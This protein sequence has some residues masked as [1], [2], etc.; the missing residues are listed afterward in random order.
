MLEDETQAVSAS[1]AT[2]VA[3]DSEARS[4]PQRRSGIQRA[5]VQPG[6]RIGE[7]QRFEI[8]EQAGVGGMG[9][10]FRANDRQL[11]RSVAIKFFVPDHVISPDELGALLKQEARATARLS[12]EN[13]VRIFDLGQWNGLPFLV[14]EY[15]EGEPLTAILKRQRFDLPRATDLMIEVAQG[16]DH[17]HGHGIIHRDLK[18]AN[19]LILKSGR[20]KIL[21]FGIAHFAGPKPL[22]GG[23]APKPQKVVG[24]PAYMAPEQW[25]GGEQDG[26]VDIW[27]AGVLYYELL[28]GKL[29]PWGADIPSIFAWLSSREPAPSARAVRPDLPEAVDAI[30]A[31]ALTRQPADR[32]ENARAFIDA[33]DSVRRPSSL[34]AAPDKAKAVRMKPERRQLTVIAAML[35]GLDGEELDI[36]EMGELLHDFHEL[37]TE[38]VMEHGGCVATSVGGKLIACFGYPAAQEDDAQRAVRAALRI[39][40]RAG[41]LRPAS[42]E[43]AS[44]QVKVGVHTGL[45]IVETVTGE[46]E[47]GIPAIQ[48][49]APDI[50][51]RLADRAEPSSVV[52]SQA[53]LVL[54]SGLFATEPL[55]R[56]SPARGGSKV[57]VMHRVLRELEVASRFEQ[58]FSGAGTALVGRDTEAGLLETWWDQAKTGSG[59]FVCVSGDAGIGK[60]R[61][62]QVL[63]RRVEEGGH[64]RMTCQC[65]P[66]SRSS[67]LYPVIQLLNRSMQIAPEDSAPDRI[68]KIEA[69]LQ[70]L[71]F[72]LADLV[73]LFAALLSVELSPPYAPPAL[74][75]ERQKAKTLEAIAALILR[76]AERGPVLFTVEDLHWI[77]PSTLELLNVLYREAPKAKLLVLLTFRPDFRAPWPKAHLHEIALDR[78]SPDLTT[79]MIEQASGGKTLP[80]EVVEQLVLR[81]DGIPLF[82]E[83][84][85]R[86]VLSSMEAADVAAGKTA[87]FARGVAIPAT[88][89]EL[90]LARFDQLTGTGKEVAQLGSVL[91]R[92]FDYR[93]L[94]AVA[95]MDDASL[96][97]GLRKLIG[98]ELLYYQGQIPDSTYM[99]KHALLQEAA[100]QSLLRSSRQRY[101]LEVARAFESKFPSIGETQP[102]LVAHHYQEG[103]DV[104]RAIVQWEKAGARATQRS[105][106]IEAISHYEKALEL[107]EKGKKDKPRSIESIKRELGLCIAIGSPLMAT[108]G[109]AAPEVEKVYARARE[110]CQLAGEDSQLFPAMN[111]LWQFYMVGGQIPVSRDLGEELLRIA[112]GTQNP[113]FLVLAHRAL[114]TSRFLLGELEPAVDHTE[115]GLGLYDPQKHGSLAFRHGHDPGVAHNL[116]AAWA[117]VLLGHL[118]R[119]LAAARR[120]LGLAEELA[121]PLSLAF[122]LSYTAMIHQLRSEPEAALALAERALPI[123][124]EHRFTLWTAWATIQRGYALAVTGKLDE[125]LAELIKGSNGW[126]NTGARSGMTYFMA[127]R[128]DVLA[129]QGRAAE[130]LEVIEEGLE[131]ATRLSEHFND[132]ELLRQKGD[133]TQAL[134]SEKRDEAEA[135]YRRGLEHARAQ[136]ARLHELRLAM[137]LGDLLHATGRTGEARGLLS[138]VLGWFSE[139]LETADVKRARGLLE[140][141]TSG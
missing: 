44:A 41:D 9:L 37:C 29:P 91:G 133:L 20:A 140:A 82:V 76:M 36:E 58:A 130:A 50:A 62:V 89:Q 85:T 117:L 55:A 40:E 5:P 95:P 124:T 90:L 103:G 56:P 73:P 28:T 83:E 2:A 96:E 61:L 26:R 45:V 7:D 114:A 6:D 42:D 59:L 13:I 113:T 21:D 79:A 94:K 110:L 123:C 129:R 68:R 38:V 106:N 80:H 11:D 87:T 98:A 72:P 69:A 125:G 63:R 10:V 15:L 4:G 131:K 108:K 109:Y 102:E 92:D 99:F 65:R 127:L 111:G 60:S 71:D 51:A 77:D 8:L 49:E 116:Y 47:R 66:H 35:A 22:P 138:E 1:A 136:A 48:G 126:L 46:L 64:V 97:E 120:A 81:S 93:L 107:L 16:L 33:L 12:H 17:A 75:P 137:S 84:L 43:G 52:V 14:M 53:T 30:L 27:A 128:G 119:A 18:P 39:R 139:G 122:S 3:T 74:T 31:R 105:A 67:A 78:L 118:D 134:S 141:W 86:M 121:H 32:F 88:L 19:V 57:L 25:S 34:P 132:A 101:H 104:E 54:V 70:E 112:E 24:T 115:R 135:I 23:A 100:Y